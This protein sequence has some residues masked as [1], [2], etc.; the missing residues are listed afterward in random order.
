LNERGYDRDDIDA[1]IAD[2]R[3]DAAARGLTFDTDMAADTTSLPGM[4]DEYESNQG[5]EAHEG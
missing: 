3:E 5:A 4:V 2:E 1:E